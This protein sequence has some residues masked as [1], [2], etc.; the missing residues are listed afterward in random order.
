MKG[1]SDKQL[2]EIDVE[3]KEAVCDALVNALVGRVSGGDERGRAILG[4]SPRRGLFAGQLLP[5]FDVGGVVDE[6]SDIRIASVGID[7]V[8]GAGSGAIIRVAPR[9]SIYVRVI[10]LWSDLVAGGRRT[11]LR[12]QAAQEHPAADRRHNTRTAHARA[13]GGRR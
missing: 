5:R 8:V 10:P 12:L 7:L 6:T 9:F 1:L 2:G 3:L 13:A 11:R 4:S